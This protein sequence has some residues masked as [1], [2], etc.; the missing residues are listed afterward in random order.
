MSLAAA[1]WLSAVLSSLFAGPVDTEGALDA[2]LSS[3]K[4]GVVLS[5][6]RQL[7]QSFLYSINEGG[8]NSN[9]VIAESTS[10]DES[11][12]KIDA[13]ARSCSST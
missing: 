2:V 9:S 1:R 3:A 6:G 13:V 7:L 4:L 11:F 8:D 5:E 12:P 10:R